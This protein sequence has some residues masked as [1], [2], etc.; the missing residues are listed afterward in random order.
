MYSLGSSRETEPN[1]HDNLSIQS[2]IRKSHKVVS[3]VSVLSM[4]FTRN[5]A[6]INDFQP[7]CLPS[8]SPLLFLFSLFLL[9]RTPILC[10]LT[11]F[12]FVWVPFSW[13]PGESLTFTLLIH[14]FDSTQCPICCSL[15][16][17][18]F[19]TWKAWLS[20]PY[21]P[22]QSSWLCPRIAAVAA[23]CLILLSPTFSISCIYIFPLEAVGLVLKGDLLSI[24]FVFKPLMFV[25][26]HCFP[27]IPHP[28]FLFLL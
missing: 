8:Y 3:A 9:G 17:L 7:L 18:K 2:E 5:T 13:F 10:K 25:D 11:P 28:C 15:I 26:R 19:L 6:F 20:F 24:L 12:I 22:P 21:N 14:Q 16:P 1:A 27:Y 23:H 4:M